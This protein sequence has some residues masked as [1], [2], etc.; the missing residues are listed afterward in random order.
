MSTNNAYQVG[1]NARKNGFS[2]EDN[3]YLDEEQLRAWLEGYYDRCAEEIL[4]ILKEILD[5][6]REKERS[7]RG[8]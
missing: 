6:E 4:P 7:K 2:C 8:L 5:S 3:P 1:Y